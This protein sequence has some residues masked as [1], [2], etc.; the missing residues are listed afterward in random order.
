[1][2]HQQ[3]GD[4]HGQ[5]RSEQETV[6][7]VHAEVSWV[8][9]NGALLASAPSVPCVSDGVSYDI[10]LV[11]ASSDLLNACSFLFLHHMHSPSLSSFHHTLQALLT[12]LLLYHFLHP[13]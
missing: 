3:K 8:C 2:V 12:T 1:M 10:S 5:A 13:G 7:A 6:H 4:G 9:R 11:C